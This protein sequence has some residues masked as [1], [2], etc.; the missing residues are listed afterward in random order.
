M[1]NPYTCVG[2]RSDCELFAKVTMH[3]GVEDSCDICD[4]NSSGTV[5]VRTHRRSQHEECKYQSSI[6][7]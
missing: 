7:I 2:I 4:I 6:C 3:Q 5:A 1:K